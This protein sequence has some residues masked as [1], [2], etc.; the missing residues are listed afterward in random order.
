MTPVLD[1]YGSLDLFQA[2]DLDR[3]TLAGLKSILDQVQAGIH[4]QKWQNS[5][6]QSLSYYYR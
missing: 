4:I 1:D 2:V 5:L 3:L 6:D